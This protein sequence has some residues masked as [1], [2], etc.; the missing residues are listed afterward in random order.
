M[1]EY[2]IEHFCKLITIITVLL[3][4]STH[5]CDHRSFLLCEF[6]TAVTAG[7][8]VGL[9]PSIRS[10][11]S[12]EERPLLGTCPAVC[13][14]DIDDQIDDQLWAEFHRISLEFI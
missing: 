2:L 1:I 8:L 13:R 5:I 11:W 3:L 9:A 12:F 4:S 6:V 7:G 10:N 14:H